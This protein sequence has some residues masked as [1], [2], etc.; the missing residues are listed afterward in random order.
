MEKGYYFPPL[1]KNFFHAGKFSFQPS[2][3]EYKLNAPKYIFGTEGFDKKSKPRDLSVSPRYLKFH[4][5]IIHRS[6]LLL[7][8]D[9]TDSFPNSKKPPI[10][11]VKIHDFELEKWRKRHE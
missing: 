2:I 11:L 3:Q 10:T 1:R 7:S 9:T 5:D 8:Q 6:R 4:K